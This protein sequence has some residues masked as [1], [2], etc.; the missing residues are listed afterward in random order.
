M[1][2]YRFYRHT[3]AIHLTNISLEDWSKRKLIPDDLQC[4][5]QMVHNKVRKEPISHRME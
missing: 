4:V 5:L 2:L 3:T 1:R